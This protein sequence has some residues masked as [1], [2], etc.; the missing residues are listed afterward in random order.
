MSDDY[1]KVIDALD[2]VIENHNA[3]ARCELPNY[4][5]LTDIAYNKIREC[6]NL[7]E[8]IYTIKKWK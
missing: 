6:R 8:V 7:L 5:K 2:K 3:S 4:F 1:L